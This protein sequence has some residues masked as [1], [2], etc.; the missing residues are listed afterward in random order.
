MSA[1][2]A[3]GDNPLI[4]E[5]VLLD[6]VFMDVVSAVAVGN[7][8]RVVS[9]LE[10]MHGTQQRTHEGIHSGKVKIPKNQNRLGEFVKMDEA[11]HHNLERLAAAARKDN[12]GDM[13]SITK[14]L[15]DGCVNCHKIF[16]D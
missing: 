15:L 14:T 5:M 13:L 10:P 3:L 12:K 2:A 1:Q 16:K 7:G 11:F 8:N 6:R 4:D 9:A